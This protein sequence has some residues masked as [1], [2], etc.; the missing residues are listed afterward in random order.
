MKLNGRKVLLGGAFIMAISALFLGP[1]A[2]LRLPNGLALIFI[3]LVLNGI[4]QS[5]SIIPLMAEI[6]KAVQEEEFGIFQKTEDNNSDKPDKANESINEL[7]CDKAASLYNVLY[8]GS[9]GLSPVL[10]GALY[11]LGGFRFASDIMALTATVLF[12]FFLLR[13]GVLNRRNKSED[14]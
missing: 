1:S 8:A 14:F 4:A 7:I 2:F 12:F 13:G 9:T 5:L 11:D 3:G 10:G 6:I